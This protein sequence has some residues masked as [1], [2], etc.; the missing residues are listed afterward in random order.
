MLD[1]TS[2]A[3]FMISGKFTGP[4]R[5]GIESLTARGMRGKLSTIGVLGGGGQLD[6]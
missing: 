5:A 3:S 4:S 1:T 2:A 6:A